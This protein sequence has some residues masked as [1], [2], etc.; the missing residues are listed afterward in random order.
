MKLCNCEAGLC[1]AMRDQAIR[2]REANDRR[3]HTRRS[4]KV[5]IRGDPPPV[6]RKGAPT[7][8]CLRVSP[9]CHVMATIPYE[10]AVCCASQCV[11]S[12]FISSVRILIFDLCLYGRPSTEV[13]SSVARWC[14]GGVVNRHVELDGTGSRLMVH[15]S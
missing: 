4:C 15:Y 13:R 14:R 3:E 7:C 1:C 12:T 2:A 8:R 5:V 11:C 6:G 9:I 10:E